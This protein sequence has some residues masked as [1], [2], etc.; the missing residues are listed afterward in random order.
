MH[1]QRPTRSPCTPQHAGHPR[2]SDRGH[3]T[4]AIR[5][6]YA[7]ASEGNRAS[8][9]RESEGNRARLARMPSHSSLGCPRI[10]RSDGLGCSR[11][12]SD[13]FGWP[14]SNGLGCPACW[15][16]HGDLW[17]LHGLHGDLPRSLGV[18]GDLVGRWAC[19]VTY[20]GTVEITP[21]EQLIWRGHYLVKKKIQRIISLILPSMVHAHSTGSP[22]EQI[23]GQGFIYQTSSIKL[24]M[25]VY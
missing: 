2:P 25:D 12:A 22:D 4:E 23:C 8:Y 1:A 14:R 3:P 9:A 5:T 16:V 19:M 11:M 10:A 24:N 6:S 20:M 21:S 13:A 15:D 7:R 17:G 18:H